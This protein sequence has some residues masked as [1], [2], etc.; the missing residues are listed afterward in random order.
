MCD[1]QTFYDDI[2]HKMEPRKAEQIK[3]FIDKM[4]DDESNEFKLMKKN[5][6]KLILYNKRE[7][8]KPLIKDIEA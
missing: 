3:K 2:Q 1:I 5:E 7:T 8:I 4:N 6:I